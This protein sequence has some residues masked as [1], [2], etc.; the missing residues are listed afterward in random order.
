MLSA[1]IPEN[2]EQRI[3]SLRDM[4]LLSSPREAD[5]DRVTRIASKLFG[6]G[7]AA[8]TLVDRHLEPARA[9]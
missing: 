6:T 8:I 1:P 7:I 5:F 9:R 4:A 3:A 2:D